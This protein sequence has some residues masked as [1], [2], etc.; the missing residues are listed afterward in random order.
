MKIRK[1]KEPVLRGAPVAGQRCPRVSASCVPLAARERTTNSTH[2]CLAHKRERRKQREASQLGR[3]RKIRHSHIV[4]Q[5][6]RGVTFVVFA[7]P[8]RLHTSHKVTTRIASMLHACMTCTQ[9]QLPSPARQYID[10]PKD[11]YLNSICQPPLKFPQKLNNV[12][13]SPAVALFAWQ[14]IYYTL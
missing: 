13:E 6:D 11:R 1:E 8:K 4:Q 9:L 12:R 2:I 14:Y 10:S 5:I 7:P 3:S